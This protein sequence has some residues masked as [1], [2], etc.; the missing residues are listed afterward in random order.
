MKKH[1]H[2]TQQRLHIRILL[3][4]LSTLELLTVTVLTQIPA[5]ANSAQRYWHGVTSSGVIISDGDCPI[6]VER[7]VLTFDL[8]TLPDTYYSPDD[9]QG[10]S[11]SSYDAR[12]TAA[13]TFYNPSDATVTARLL[14]P[15][16]TGAG[17]LYGIDDTQRYD[18]TVDGQPI[19]KNVRHTLNDYGAQ[20]ELERDLGRLHDDYA[21]DSFFRPDQTVTC[22]TY[23]VT[24]VD[25]EAYRAANIAFDIKDAGGSIRLYWP[26]M[27]G[28]HTRSDGAVRLS[29]WVDESRE[30]TLYVI[31][32]TPLLQPDW[33]CYSNGGVRDKEIIDGT[34]VFVGETQMT[35][36]ELALSERP[37]ASPVSDTDW[38][39]AVIAEFKQSTVGESGI[40]SSLPSL[41]LSNRLMR[42]YEY[43]ITLGAG[44]RIV[45]TVTAPMYPTID[46]GYSPSIY[47]YTYLLSPAATWRSFGTLE[48]NINTPYFLLDDTTPAGFTQ[49]DTGYTLRTDRLPD[50]EL[51]FSLS[52]SQSPERSHYS[53][54]VNIIVILTVIAL[55]VVA[56][57]VAATI[58]AVVVCLIITGKKKNK[59]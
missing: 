38:Y 31:G 48:I 49:T 18:I 10:D 46:E 59:Q 3:T 58:V 39:N 19:Q 30:L 4:L 34:A 55:I 57:N 50:G 8:A 41:D 9:R 13:Y 6:E 23:R 7:E 47:N 20:F 27:S 56:L 5:S 12:V 14:F 11:F 37:E 32:D 26:Q 51:T 22:Y 36:L 42:W 53:Y 15:F 54:T 16:G 2:R 35:L 43:D 44:Q 17:Y 24:G 40:I 29:A 28:L 21:A 25:T 45:N 33:K 1:N 52:E